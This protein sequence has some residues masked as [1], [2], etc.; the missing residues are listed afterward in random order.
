MKFG[1]CK[2]IFLALGLAV[3]SIAG[4][5]SEAAAQ[6]TVPPAARQT[7]IADRGKENVIF[8]NPFGIVFGVFTAEYE[9]KLNSSL[10]LAVAGTFWDKPTGIDSRYH[11][12]TAALRFY[13]MERVMNGFSISPLL[14]FVS[15]DEEPKPCT[16]DQNNSCNRKRTTNGIYGVQVDYGW[17][18]GPNQRFAVGTGLGV[19]R[20]IGSTG[21]DTRVIPSARFQIGYAF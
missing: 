16:V 14:G 7:Q 19:R 11:G 6:W 2:N 8:I 12:A 4:S 21:G 9:R 20:I 13:P 5:T 10:S 15:F 17:L 3:L 18:L 1:V